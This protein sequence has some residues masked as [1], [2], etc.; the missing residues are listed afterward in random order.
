M[1]ARKVAAVVRFGVQKVTRVLGDVK[2]G[3]VYCADCPRDDEARGPCA[4]YPRDCKHMKSYLQQEDG[5]FRVECRKS[6]GKKQKG[7][8]LFAF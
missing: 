4:G 2:L 5:R 1:P 6:S 7:P 8:S 3:G